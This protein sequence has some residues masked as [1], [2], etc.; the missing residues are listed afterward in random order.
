MVEE[1]GVDANIAIGEM[2]D[3]FGDHGYHLWDAI[4]ELVDNSVDSF[5]KHHRKLKKARPNETKRIDINVDNKARSVTI[6]DN[7]HGMSLKELKRALIPAKANLD[8]D[9]IG[10][11]GMGLKTAASWLGKVWTVRTKQLGSTEEYIAK[12]DIPSL[13][14]SLNN[15]IPIKTKKLG[16]SERIKNQSYTI[17]EIT[18]GIR[19]YGSSTFTKSQRMLEI[20]YQKVVSKDFQ[21]IWRGKSIEFEEPAVLVGKHPDG[22]KFKYDFKIKPFKLKGQKISGRYGIY[23]DTKLG[24]VGKQGPYAGV[25]AFWRNRVILSKEGST[26]W[27]PGEIFGN[28]AGDLARQRVFLHLTMNDA[29]VNSLKTDFSWVAYTHE[30]LEAEIIKQTKGHIKEIRDFARSVRKE[31]APITDTERALLDERTRSQLESLGPTIQQAEITAG[32]DADKLSKSQIKELESSDDAPYLVSINGGQPNVKFYVAKKL[33]PLEPF[34]RTHCEQEKVEIFINAKHPFYEERISTDTALYNVYRDILGAI[35]LSVYSS[36]R[37]DKV[38]V[39]QFIEKTLDSY[40][41]KL[42]KD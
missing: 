24:A 11:Y 2:L 1:Q 32:E 6:S 41:R 9:G 10:K 23:F 15:F 39:K 8:Q 22:K 3:T 19:K 28:A 7:A 17:I 31:K 5:T 42:L 27:W 37:Y 14:Q 12:V 25:T 16:T 13:K 33:H 21:I 30:K 38:D 18:S 4:F 34:I 26:Q 29:S 36:M 35:S 20:Y 40:L